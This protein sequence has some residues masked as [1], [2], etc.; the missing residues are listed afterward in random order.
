MGPNRA[1]AL[2]TVETCA[3]RE[4]SDWL[5]SWIKL[6]LGIFRVCSREQQ[7]FWWSE[8]LFALWLRQMLRS[9]NDSAQ[10]GTSISL[11]SIRRT[12]SRSD[13]QITTRESGG[14]SFIAVMGGCFWRAN[15]WRHFFPC[16]LNQPLGDST[17]QIH[18]RP[19]GVIISLW[20][21][22]LVFVFS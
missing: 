11:V 20:R 18:T 4:K 14:Q 19:R 21:K 13:N 15:R 2:G 16:T 10:T 3:W 9:L 5:V 22:S 12:T 7:M 1:T 17:S 8:T 6:F